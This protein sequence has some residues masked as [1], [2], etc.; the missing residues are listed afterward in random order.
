[1][2]LGTSVTAAAVVLAGCSSE[3]DNTV[4]PVNAPNVAVDES[5]QSGSAPEQ[6]RAV[7]VD[8]LPFN[9]DYFTQGLEVDQ[10]GNLLIG[11]GQYGESAIYRITPG[12]L[13]VLDQADMDE[14]L[15]G[16]GI[17]R[18]D[19]SIWQLSWQAGEA[20]KRDAATLEET[21]R[22]SYPGE[23]WG[24]CR[25][26]DELIFSDGTDEL[27]H[28]D[29]TTFEEHGRTSVTLDRQPVD[30]INELECVDGQVYA[31]VWLT[32]D[33]YRI[34]PASGEVTARIDT[35]ELIN[36][37]EPDPDNVLNGI[38]HI[39]GTDEFYVTGKRWPDLYKVRFE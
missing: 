25:M 13:E 3:Q 19:D 26:D 12:S 20:I 4:T 35:S 14:D 22:V 8:T 30:N 18:V 6:L 16:E 31:N 21:D 7:V 29:P 27:R 11:T 17:T 15:F 28:L 2:G 9:T 24:V 32:E 34:D 23:G 36:N 39:P 1:M 37:A 10:D 38:A 5:T 33:I